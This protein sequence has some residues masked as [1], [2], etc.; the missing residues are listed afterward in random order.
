MLLSIW[1]E[2]SLKY[3]RKSIVAS[4]P[5][6]RILLSLDDMQCEHVCELCRKDLDVHTEKNLIGADLRD[7]VSQGSREWTSAT[8]ILGGS[9]NNKQ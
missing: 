5:K 7:V 1:N 3:Q 4:K 9:N 2:S 6:D 8:S